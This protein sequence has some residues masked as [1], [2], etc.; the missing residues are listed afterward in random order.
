MS[1]PGFQAINPACQIASAATSAVDS[2]FTSAANF[3]AQAAVS[4]TNWLWSQI[5]S[6][7]AVDLG[8]PALGRQLQITGA[9]AGVLCLGLFALQ[10]IVAALRREAGA[11]SRAAK[12]LFI[13]ALGSAFALAA[14]RAL[15]GAVDSLADGVVQ[16]T[17]GTNMRGIGGQLALVNVTQLS[18]PAVT[19]AMA[20]AILASVVIVWAAMMIRKMMLIIAAVLAPLAFAGATAEIT[21]SWV[22]KWVEFVVAMI[23]SKLILVI[24]LSTGVAA[25]QGAGATGGSTT[26]T[27]TQ[28]VVGALIL[29]LGGLAPWLAMRMCVFVGDTMHAAHLTAGQASAGGRAAIAAPQ[30]VAVLAAQARGFTAM[31][32]VAARAATARSESSTSVS[33]E[34]PPEGA[35]VAV[36]TGTSPSGSTAQQASSYAAEPGPPRSSVP[37]SPGPERSTPQSAPG[38]QP[39]QPHPTAPPGASPADRPE[40]QP[41]TPPR[42]ERP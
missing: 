1:C 2:T 32:S 22:R 21:S 27:G 16:H 18:N 4:G 31:P 12:G 15:I 33:S 28:L 17:M 37:T 42:R 29:L 8:S 41:S 38:Q 36:L 13:S 11:L 5:D 34:R 6:A 25:M 19:L 7:T 9:I 14:T 35:P 26:Q 20:L 10:L 24:I 23:V 30:K 39:A 40:S 3:F